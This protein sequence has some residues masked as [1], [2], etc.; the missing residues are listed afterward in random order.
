MFSTAGSPLAARR[1]NALVLGA[2]ALL[3]LSVIF[4]G[5]GAEGPIAN[6]W[7]EASAAILMMASVASHFSGR[8]LPSQATIPIW[9]AVAVLA[10]VAAQLIPLPPS[11]WTGLPGRELAVAVSGIASE[12]ESW[13]PLS[14]DPEATRRA[15]AAL[16][17]P[18]AIFIASVGASRAGILVLLKTVVVAALLS[19]V[20]G[21]IQI[22][23]GTPDGL[24][25][26]GDPEAGIAT[27]FFANPNHQAQLMLAAVIATGLLIRLEEPQV[28]IRRIKGDLLFHLAWLAFP[29]FIAVTVAAQS[30]AG[31]VLLAP[32][33]VAAVVLAISRKDP[34]RLFTVFI[35]LVAAVVALVALAPGSTSRSMKLQSSLMGE[36]RIISLPDIQFTLRQYWP[37]GSG[38]G[39]FAPVYQ[40]NEDLDLVL[41]P[42]LNHAHNEILEVLVEAGLA[43]VILLAAAAMAIGA[44]F[45]S[46]IRAKRA[47]DTGLALGGLAMLTLML[48]HSL[49][50]YPLRM[51]TLAAIA[52]LA[53]AL[54]V[55]P[56][57]R[58]DAPKPQEGARQRRKGFATSSSTGPSQSRRAKQW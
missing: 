57:Q 25:P 33:L 5:G 34:T 48:L 43:G 58:R 16:L 23:L 32:A 40:S 12:R 39:T 36:G 24:A 14:L 38:F 31:L 56:P 51:H 1:F 21:A 3:L 49:V 44:R 22:A 45:W 7:L 41:G 15:G 17:V 30:R 19:A 42:R 54:F 18:I 10:V 27:G 8:P 9:L 55:A 47:T 11:L 6:G 20:L 35:L 53:V 13:R 29:I 52:G 37:V 4:G 28:R 46:L 2:S 26:Y 50:D